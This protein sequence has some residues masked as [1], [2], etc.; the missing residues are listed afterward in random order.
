[1]DGS[2]RL[3]QLLSLLLSQ[4]VSSGADLAD[5]LGTTTRT[6][7]RD[8]ARLRAL[9]YQIESA[10]ATRGG[11]RLG[12]HGRLPPL[13]VDVAEA[14]A[15][16]MGLR[17]ASATADGALDGVAGAALRKLDDVLP[18][19]V[20]DRVRALNDVTLRLQGRAAPVTD[21]AVLA[22]VAGACHRSDGLRFAYRTHTA[23]AGER[24]VIP[25][26]LV[27]DGRRW[28]LVARDTSH[29]GWRT[30]RVDRISAPALTGHRHVIDDPPDAAILVSVGTT[31]AAWDIRAVL[32]LH[33]EVADATVRF[34][35]SVGIVTADGPRH[36]LLTVGANDLE[37]LVSFAAGLTFDFDVVEPPEL[38]S[39]LAAHARR[40]AR[41]H[42][43]STRSR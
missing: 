42:S 29:R 1:M 17:V 38:R 32:R 12:A 4:Q 39:A 6:V 8:V 11:Y 24:S 3:L 28:Y 15:I 18:G 23:G 21:P 16:V 26:R 35:A 40:L 25:Y 27:H 2:S 22:V 43:S 36:S 13:L 5:R 19:V 10:P 33:L 31:V 37:A 41:H 9:G 7:R 34:P 30:Y 14:T 20:R